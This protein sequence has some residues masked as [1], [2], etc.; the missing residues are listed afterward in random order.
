MNKEK[1]IIIF[2]VII[3]AI[4]SGY[5]IYDHYQTINILQSNTNRS[6][7]LNSA[8]NWRAS[9]NNSFA[10]SI[11]MVIIRSQMTIYK[12]SDIE[13]FNKL[14]GYYGEIAE[15]LGTT[16]EHLDEIC[17]M[18]QDGSEDEIARLIRKKYLN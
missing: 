9:S 8:K 10:L 16:E 11:D 17:S 13:T 6:N 7:A 14:K 1:I 18:R 2:T 4:F 3:M 15:Y 12:T 5:L